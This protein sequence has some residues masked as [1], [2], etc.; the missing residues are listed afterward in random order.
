MFQLQSIN[1][2]G[3]LATPVYTPTPYGSTSPAV[4]AQA[5]LR[6]LITAYPRLPSSA[7][8]KIDPFIAGGGEVTSEEGQ[9]ALEGFKTQDARLAPL[10]RAWVA[11]GKKVDGKSPSFWRILPPPLLMCRLVM[12]SVELNDAWRSWTNEIIEDG[13]SGL[14]AKGHHDLTPFVS[15]EGGLDATWKKLSTRKPPIPP[16]PHPYPSA[17][18]A[19]PTPA[20]YID[21]PTRERLCVEKASIWTAYFLHNLFVTGP[22]AREAVAGVRW[23][24]SLTPWWALRQ[25]RLPP[26]FP[27]SFANRPSFINRINGSYLFVQLLKITDPSKMISALLALILARPFGL[28]SLFQKLV[29]AL[30]GSQEAVCR[31]EA[32][33][34][35]SRIVSEVG[36]E[37]GKKYCEAVRAYVGG[38]S[39][40][41]RRETGARAEREGVSLIRVIIP[42]EE[43]IPASAVPLLEKLVSVLSMARDY[44]SLIEFC[45]SATF[46]KMIKA[47]LTVVLY[48]PLTAW[49]K[50]CKL[51]DRV[52]DLQVFLADLVETA[53]AKDAGK[54]CLVGSCRIV[55]TDGCWGWLVDL[56]SFL[57]LCQ[58]HQQKLYYLFS[59]SSSLRSGQVPILQNID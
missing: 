6:D 50:H 20:N 36:A 8:D 32:E 22:S 35:E 16:I 58:R 55:G 15:L 1:D 33:G 52:Y 57:A 43:A 48:G 49:S 28:P 14:T 9:L 2:K 12:G 3:S 4:N 17:N 39:V 38:T 44:E 29:S 25:V 21:L 24:L 37:R 13:G 51:S 11:A 53:K 47:T 46:V 34:V 41:E 5:Y 56:A 27:P 40:D 19:S 42:K 26:P 18:I 31:K 45:A 59:V 10:H 7:K 54:F 23:I 30:L